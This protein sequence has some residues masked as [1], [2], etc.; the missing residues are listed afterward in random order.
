MHLH[1]VSITAIYSSPYRRAIETVE[2]L[3]G[4]RKIPILVREDL[5]ERWLADRILED[6]EWLDVYRRTWDDIDFCPDGGESRRTTQDRALAAI[7]DVRQR[8]VGETVV[9]SSHGGLIGCLL[10]ALDGSMEFER[11]LEMP[12]PA[13]FAL[14]DKAGEWRIAPLPPT[15]SAIEVREARSADVAAIADL[16]LRSRR[17]ARRGVY[18]DDYLAAMTIRDAEA[19]ALGCLQREGWRT[20]VA[21]LN[22]AVAA[23]ATTG[24]WGEDL[25]GRT[26]EIDDLYVAPEHF[27]QGIGSYVLRH[28]ERQVVAQGQEAIV[29]WVRDGDRGVEA[30]YSAQGFRSQ[31]QTKDL[32]KDHPR[33]FRL[34]LK[35]VTGAETMLPPS[36]RD[37]LPARPT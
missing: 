2:P 36:R 32:V 5:A 35:A 28:V 19:A 18:T 17:I 13:L 30:F 7:E 29:L 9:V 22:G 34:W 14:T 16:S 21:E 25:T 20:W 8:H 23:Y 31:E 27:R 26:A 37:H 11:A 6:Q 12:M 24:P 33:V 1:P 3:A 4:R 15:A 10:R